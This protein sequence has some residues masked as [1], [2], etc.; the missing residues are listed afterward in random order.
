MTRT[1]VNGKDILVVEVPDEAKH[2]TLVEGKMFLWKT[3]ITGNESYPISSV[4]L[5][6]GQ[7]EIVLDTAEAVEKDYEKI[8]QWEGE[9]YFDYVFNVRL[10]NSAKESFMSLIFSLYLRTD[11]RYIVLKNKTS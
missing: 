2:P 11:K 4:D 9:E 7:W 5:P 6:P 10:W 3:P 8:V 1:T